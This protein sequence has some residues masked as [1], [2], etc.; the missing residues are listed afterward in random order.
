M[1]ITRIL[2]LTIL[3]ISEI[4]LRPREFEENHCIYV[5]S[6]TRLPTQNQCL[7]SHWQRTCIAVGC[8]AL[9]YLTHIPI[10]SKDSLNIKNTFLLPVGNP[11]QLCN[12]DFSVARGF[13]CLYVYGG[14]TTPSKKPK[15]NQEK[16]P[17]QPKPNNQ[18]KKI[19]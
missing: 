9:L 16:K 2:K 13:S 10:K 1:Y 17:H 12:C 3:T 8:T 4:V 14:T 5:L 11:G 7:D 15:P 19:R 18:T 6:P